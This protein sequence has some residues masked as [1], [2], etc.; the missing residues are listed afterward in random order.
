MG[1]CHRRFL[2]GKSN[3]AG[4]T[5]ASSHA[6]ACEERCLTPAAICLCEEE[7][8]GRGPEHSRPLGN[9]SSAGAIAWRPCSLKILHPPS[10]NDPW[11]FINTLPSSPGTVLTPLRSSEQSDRPHPVEVSKYLQLPREGSNASPLACYW[12]WKLSLH[13]S[14]PARGQWALRGACALQC[15]PTSVNNFP[16]LRFFLDL[17]AMCA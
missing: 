12:S 13:V 4:D 2:P 7:M 17:R 10:R 14:V 8:G 5:E 9:Q 15:G 3:G 16:A 11:Y 1:R 6:R